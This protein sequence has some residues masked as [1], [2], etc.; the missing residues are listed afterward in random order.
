MKS[1]NKRTEGKKENKQ[2]ESMRRFDHVQTWHV[3][4][5]PPKSLKML[6]PNRPKN[7]PTQSVPLFFVLAFFLFRLALQSRPTHHHFLACSRSSCISVACYED[8][9]VHAVLA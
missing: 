7:D 3:E 1:E 2:L 4:A 9:A 8:H 5:V 6:S